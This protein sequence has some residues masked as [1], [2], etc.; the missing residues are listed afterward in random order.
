M[1]QEDT[2]LA[3]PGAPSSG[4]VEHMAIDKTELVFVSTQAPGGIFKADIERR[5]LDDII[6][7]D[8]KLLLNDTPWCATMADLVVDESTSSFIGLS[9][10]CE[11]ESDWLMMRELSRFF[12]PSLLHI[13]DRYFIDGEEQESR[14]GIRERR[15]ELQWAKSEKPCMRWAQLICGQWFWCYSNASDY[16]DTKSVCGLVLTDLDEV[17]GEHDLQ[18]PKTNLRPLKLIFGEHQLPPG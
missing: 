6:F 16:I 5:F 1:L 2:T 12:D 11:N 4:L 8:A 17:L 18:F 3:E 14:R 7:N 15:V 10:E 13:R 9:F